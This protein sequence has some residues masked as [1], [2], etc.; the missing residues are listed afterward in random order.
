M[1]LLIR[2]TPPAVHLA[3]RKDSRTSRIVPRWC[4]SNA[5]SVSSKLFSR[6]QRSATCDAEGAPL[7]IASAKAP[8]RSRLTTCTVGCRRSHAAT[9][10]ASRVGSRSTTRPASRSQ[11]I[12][13]YRCPFFQ[14]HSSI[15]S[16]RGDGVVA[17]W[18]CPRR[19]RSIVAL[20]AG[21]PSLPANR[22]LARP[23]SARLTHVSACLKRLLR[24]AYRSTIPGRRS[25]K[26]R[27][28]QRSSTQKNLRV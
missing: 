25:V 19:V 20:L 10:S 22:A 12:V 21:R 27:R 3:P 28:E 8:A 2:G 5:I 16:T 14:A 15:P 6:C 1:W 13:P 23:P 24:R 7:A 17:G 4:S 9:V 11:R 26:I 18:L